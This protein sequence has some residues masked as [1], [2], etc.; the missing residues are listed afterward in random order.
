MIN[1]MLF[2]SMLFFLVKKIIS[3]GKR[4]Q[5]YFI[6]LFTFVAWGI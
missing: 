1:K 4:P 3:M 6:K 2:F 5:I